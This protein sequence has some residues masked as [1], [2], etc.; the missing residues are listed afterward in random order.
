VKYGDLFCQSDWSGDEAA[1]TVLHGGH[2]YT[3]QLGMSRRLPNICRLDCL[4]LKIMRHG[5][6]L[7]RC[8]SIAFHSGPK[9]CKYFVSPDSFLIRSTMVW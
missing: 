4:S 1:L 3:A 5:K 9:M 7:K 8:V 6:L 2:A